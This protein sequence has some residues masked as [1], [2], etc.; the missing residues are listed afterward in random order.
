MAA[1]NLMGQL[2]SKLFNEEVDF[3]SDT[4]KIM[5]LTSSATP[6]VDVHVYI[7][8]L[9][10]AET[11]GTGYT[12]GGATLA[13]KSVSYDS[14]T[15]TTTF[16]ADNVV[17]SSSEITARYCVVYDDTSS[18]IIGYADFGQD[19][20]SNGADFTVN[21]DASGIFTVVV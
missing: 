15:N 12:A 3:E 2:P 16:D 14:G 11:S 9:E 18:V 8:D 4:I 13:N 7:E 19:K 17:W 5:L 21:F 6:N 1:I 10:G 20:T